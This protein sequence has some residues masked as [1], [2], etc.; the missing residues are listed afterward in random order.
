MCFVIALEVL[1]NMPHDRFYFDSKT[2]KIVE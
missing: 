1:D 2:G